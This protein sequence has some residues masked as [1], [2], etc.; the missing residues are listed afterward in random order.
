[1][2]AKGINDIYVVSVNDMF[3]VNAW[4]EKLL[5]DEKK[6]TIKFGGLT[7]QPR[8]SAPLTCCTFQLPFHPQ[9]L[10]GAEPVRC[11]LL[12]W[13]TPPHLL[14]LSLRHSHPPWVSKPLTTPAPWFPLSALC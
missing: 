7:R 10:S 13:L 2:K 3:V 5:G 9:L 1:M 4:K 14:Q 11:R 6:G 8:V 12:L